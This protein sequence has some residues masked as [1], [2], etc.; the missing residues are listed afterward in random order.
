[1]SGKMGRVYRE[2]HGKVN[3]QLLWWIQHILEVQM[4]LQQQ[5]EQAA[6]ALLSVTNSM[7]K[8]AMFQGKDRE[9]LRRIVARSGMGE[10]DLVESVL[11]DDEKLN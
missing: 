8:M 2:L 10:D 1:M 4:D 11:P 6:N 3:P 5:I 7:E 9:I